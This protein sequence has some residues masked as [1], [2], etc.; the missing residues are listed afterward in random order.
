[1]RGPG[2]TRRGRA[3]RKGLESL[4]GRKR[5]GTHAVEGVVIRDRR[6]W[7]P[8]ARIAGAQ[9]RPGRRAARRARALED[10]KRVRQPAAAYRHLRGA[11]LEKYRAPVRGT[12]R[13]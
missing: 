11:L 3:S 1:M 8:I 10:A 13:D 2:K 9:F 4:R 6:A 12:V 7:N 5:G